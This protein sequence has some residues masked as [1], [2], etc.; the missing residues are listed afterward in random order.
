MHLTD[1]R[2]GSDSLEK[3]AVSQ[4]ASAS[5]SS[6]EA[7]VLAWIQ[8]QASS[9][10]VGTSAAAD[11]NVAPVTLVSCS[12]QGRGPEHLFSNE[13]HHCDPDLAQ[14]HRIPAVALCQGPSVNAATSSMGSAC[15]IHVLPPRMRMEAENTETWDVLVWG[16]ISSPWFLQCLSTFHQTIWSSWVLGMLRTGLSWGGG[17][18]TLL[19]QQQNP[20][21][22]ASSSA[23][24]RQGLQT[25][26][27]DLFLPLGE[28]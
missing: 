22:R 24:W 4:E 19:G 26:K 9:P 1:V 17:S 8:Y 28:L 6:G 23:G 21:G 25:Q 27:S 20:R 12:T 11:V 13:L 3:S 16:F 14:P 18:C 7:E 2:K 10:P 5:H 15:R